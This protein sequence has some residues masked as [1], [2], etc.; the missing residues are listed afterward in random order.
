MQAQRRFLRGVQGVAVVVGWLQIWISRL[1][2]AGQHQGTSPAFL[3]V[4]AAG[5]RHGGGGDAAWACDAGDAW[6]VAVRA[7]IQGVVAE[8][9][10][11]G[12]DTGVAA[13]E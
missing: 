13:P 2:L 4:W 9:H 7:C 5:I 10:G 11:D 8:V 1:D 12:E 6:C 3:A